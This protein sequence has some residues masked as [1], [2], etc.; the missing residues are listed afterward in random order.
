MKTEN[1]K[2]FQFINPIGYS[3]DKHLTVNLT[4][5]VRLIPLQAYDTV[6]D[7]FFL[8]I[9]GRSGWGVKCVMVV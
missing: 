1:P 8:S 5:P 9:N 3:P 7:R 4:N 6:R 2:Y